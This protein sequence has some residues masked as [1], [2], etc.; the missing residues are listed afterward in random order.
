M[1]EQVVEI[2]MA[3]THLG[4]L[5]KATCDVHDVQ[6]LLLGVPVSHPASVSANSRRPP[7]SR[8]KERH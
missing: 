2:R 8:N 3:V 5:Q 6:A 1:P 4:W 7:L